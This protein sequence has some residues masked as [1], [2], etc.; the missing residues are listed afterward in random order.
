MSFN[1][2]L[3]ALGQLAELFLNAREHQHKTLY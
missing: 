1:K 3:E 2:L